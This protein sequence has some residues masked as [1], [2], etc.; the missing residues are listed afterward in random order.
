VPANER[1]SQPGC[2]FHRIEHPKSIAKSN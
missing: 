2:D 1:I